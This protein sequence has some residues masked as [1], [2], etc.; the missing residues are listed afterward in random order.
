[1]SSRGHLQYAHEHCSHMEGIL[2]R[3]LWYLAGMFY[4]VCFLHV[5]TGPV[6]AMSHRDNMLSR[7]VIKLSGTQYYT[8]GDKGTDSIKHYAKTSTCGMLNLGGQPS[9]I[10]TDT[11]TEKAYRTQGLIV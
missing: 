2:Q 5:F 10:L 6:C 8:H 7:Q 3:W 4:T 11:L 1:M 9:N